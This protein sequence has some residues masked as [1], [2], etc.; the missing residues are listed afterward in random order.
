MSDSLLDLRRAL[1]LLKT[2]VKFGAVPFL[3]W[4]IRSPLSAADLAVRL[5][6]AIEELGLTYLK[7]G[8]F[9]AMRYDI[10]PGEI[11]RELNRLFENVSPL[12][13]D[14]VIGVIEAELGGPIRAF[15][16]SVRSEPI[17]SASVAQVH[18]G[19]TLNGD[20]VA[21]KVQ[22]PNIE[23]TFAADIRNLR[24][25]A[26]LVDTT[27]VLGSLSAVEMVDEFAEWT[28]RELNFVVEG[29]TADRLREEALAHEIVPRI[30]WSITTP[31]VL[32][33]ELVDG[34]SLARV[35]DLIDRGG[36]DQV[37]AVLPH[38]D[39][40]QALHHLASSSLNQ[41]FVFGF[42]H[43]DPHPGNILVRDD[44]RLAF[45]D[46]GIFGELTDYQRRVVVGFVRNIALGNIGESFRFFARQ[47]APTVET[48][49]RAF[50][51]ES[52]AGLHSWYQAS[53]S[54]TAPMEERHVG[55]YVG[56]MLSIARRNRLR[57][58]YGYLLFWRVLNALD[59]TV[60][61]LSAQFDVIAEMRD[62]F[63]RTPAAGLQ[64]DLEIP[65]NANQ[66]ATVAELALGVSRHAAGILHSLRNGPPAWRVIEEE[67]A[68][69]RRA[70][71]RDAN[72]LTASLVVV[73][74]LIL[75]ASGP[76]RDFAVPTVLAL[77]LVLSV[78][79]LWL[80]GE[81]G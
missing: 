14:Q 80:T 69:L 57:M 51:R 23:R 42:F 45:V 15:F 13:F 9:L 59:S 78:V 62:F 12:P 4:I 24:R 1:L 64:Q 77:S 16:S 50:K 36:L 19:R 25:G 71:D 56:E 79:V 53:I 20:R 6:A 72:W 34:I 2:A 21:I 38:F 74:V 31:K 65:L 81:I 60:L 67:T 76:A 70:R 48:D 3:R 10:L 5:R 18:E 22:R 11:C 66:A 39:L 30:Y 44:N 33:M 28:L 37:R 55:K 35:A 32:T 7:A 49:P 61:R 40:E 68:E 43:G 27:G 54:E 75:V 29:Q 63:E 8:Q 52:I 41:I 26:A 17:G 73:S 58:G 46:F 47:F